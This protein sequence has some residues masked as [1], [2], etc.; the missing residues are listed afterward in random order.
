MR[1]RSILRLAEV[2]LWAGAVSGA[3][4]A[5]T[6]ME[7]G[8]A[9]FRGWLDEAAARVVLPARCGECHAA[10]F[11]VWRTTRHATGFDTL[12]RSDRAKEI[13]RNLDLRLMRRSAGGVT[14][15]CLSCHYTPVPSR[16]GL[17]AGGGVSCESCHGPAREWIAIHSDYGV[18]E[19]DFQKAARLETAVH[20]EKRIADSASAGMRRSSDIYALASTCFACH[21]VPNEE[22][23]NRGGHSPGG[24]F[25]LVAGNEAIRHN[26]LD[27]YRSD[28]GRTNAERS[29]ADKR[30]LYVVGRALAVEY[31]LRG[32]AAAAEDGL[33]AAA[34]RD[35]FD[36][37]VDELFAIEER[38]AIP[39]VQSIIAASEAVEPK[40]GNGALSAAADEVGE[41]TRTFLADSGG[42]ALAASEALGVPE[43]LAA[44][45]PLW[46]PELWETISVTAVA[47][48]AAD[49][50]PPPAVPGPEHPEPDR[51]AT[52]PGDI[53]TPAAPV[54]EAAPDGPLPARASRP[55]WRDPPA[56]DFVGVPCGRCHPPQLRWWRN[57][58]HSRAADPLRQDLAGAIAI[59]RAYGIAENDVARGTETC[60]WCHGTIV[61]NPARRV[62]AGVGCQGCHGPGADYLKAHEVARYQ[63]SL[64]LGL[65][66]LRDPKT[67]AATCAGCHYITDPGLIDAGHPSG[68]DFDIVAAKGRM[69]HWGSSFGRETV[70]VATAVLRSAFSGVLASRGPVPERRAGAAPLVDGPSLSGASSTPAA[71]PPPATGE[72]APSPGAPAAEAEPTP[73]EAMLDTLR[74]HLEELFRVL[75]LRREKEPGN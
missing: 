10:E 60:M 7:E 42:E 32:L 53:R 28:D 37:A 35:R 66:D 40:V 71:E 48:P 44:L 5:E 47:V 1:V 36:A 33:Y 75:G 62:R 21:T 4:G 23:V 22:L 31:A 25:E 52:E 26:F 29:R 8:S 63:E 13:S 61:S 16:D 45:D 50:L 27:S 12:H 20:R 67:Q 24:D 51:S 73:G 72:A 74:E 14:P 68:A 19:A 15:A 43:A 34:M 11:D 6:P 38:L 3:A 17:R 9:S 59:A 64:A 49:L 46:D 70:P 69:V 58:P 2:V 56:H 30:R 18:P 65:T 39:L 41:A 55:A 54:P 57:D